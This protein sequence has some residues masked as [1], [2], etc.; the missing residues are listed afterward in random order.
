MTSS[1]FDEMGERENVPAHLRVGEEGDAM[2]LV[3]ATGKK[4]LKTTP[5][6]EQS[7]LEREKALNLLVLQCR[8]IQNQMRTECK[9]RTQNEANG[10]KNG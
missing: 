4:L 1:R 10:C 8:T 6:R 3:D 5:E 2:F 9:R 7:L